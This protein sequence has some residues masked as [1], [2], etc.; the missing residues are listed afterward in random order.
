M[1]LSQQKSVSVFL[2]HLS[3]LTAKHTQHS[4]ALKQHHGLHTFSPQFLTVFD[5]YYP[6]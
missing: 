3:L 2:V 1:E 6:S 4:H 5:D